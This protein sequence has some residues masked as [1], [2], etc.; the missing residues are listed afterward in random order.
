MLKPT[1]PVISATEIEALE[2]AEKLVDKWFAEAA[3]IFDF[4]PGHAALATLW[5]VE[6]PYMNGQVFLRQCNFGSRRWY[7]SYPAASQEL[8]RNFLLPTAPPIVHAWEKWTRPLEFLNL[9]QTEFIP[10]NLA[11]QLGSNLGALQ[12]IVDVWDHLLV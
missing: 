6:L 2:K 12:L 4:Q 5:E 11:K 1:L 7:Q 9:L 10:A 3:K 8:L